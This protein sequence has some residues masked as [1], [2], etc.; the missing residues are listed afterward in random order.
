MEQV[1]SIKSVFTLNFQHSWTENKSKWCKPFHFN[2]KRKRLQHKCKDTDRGQL[3]KEPATVNG[4][5]VIELVC[6]IAGI[7]SLAV[8]QRLFLQKSAVVTAWL[9]QAENPLWKTAMK[10]NPVKWWWETSD[11]LKLSR[12]SWIID[13]SHLKLFTFCQI[14]SGVPAVN[15][16]SLIR[17]F[18][19]VENFTADTTDTTLY[20]I[21]FRDRHRNHG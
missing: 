19:L 16:L 7:S 6:F 12:F 14:L 5:I 17:T 1:E 2:F 10:G 21:R 13:Y 20:L 3:K 11:N 15:L 8:F 9:L 4:C 18:G